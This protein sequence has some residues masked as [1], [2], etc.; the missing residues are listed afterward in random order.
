MG[1]CEQVSVIPNAFASTS[2]K[3]VH[4]QGPNYLRNLLL[5]EFAAV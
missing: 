1:Q 2:P 5:L 4:R 3:H